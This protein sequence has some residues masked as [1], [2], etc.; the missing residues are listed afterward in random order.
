MKAIYFSFVFLMIYSVAFSQ[1]KTTNYNFKS[2]I[3]ETVFGS[4]KTNS[5][6]MYSFE[7]LAKKAWVDYIDTDKI[8][9]SPKNFGRST[10]IR[11]IE[12]YKNMVLNNP[13]Q[14]VCGRDMPIDVHYEVTQRAYFRGLSDR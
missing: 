9:L 12:S 2:T 8:N 14:D 5:T 10:D 11:K 13:K 7:M 1:S 6:V 3:S 4:D